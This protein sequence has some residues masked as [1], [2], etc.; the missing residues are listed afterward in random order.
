MIYVDNFENENEFF[1]TEIP[2]NI[3]EKYFFIDYEN[4]NKDGLNGIS[5]L[6]KSDCVR[7]Y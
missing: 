6:D 5:H 4:V 3:I 2:E 7:I 1:D